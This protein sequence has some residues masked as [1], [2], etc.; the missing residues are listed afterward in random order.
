MTRI[1]VGVVDQGKEEKLKPFLDILAATGADVTVLAWGATA[2]AVVD[3]AAYDALVLC[4]GD[5]VDARRWGERNHPTVHLVPAR[6][7]EYE[8]AFARA[9]VE[10]GVPLL[11]VCRGSQIMNVALG[12]TLEQ[13]VPDVPGR[14]AHGDGAR[15]EIDVEP[16]TLLARLAPPRRRV[17]NSFHHQAV[18]RLAPSLRVAARCVDG[19]VEAV[20]GPGAFCLGVQ[21]HPEREG[22][23]EPLGSALFAELVKAAELR[24]ASDPA[25][26]S[27]LEVGP[28][29][30]QGR[31][32]G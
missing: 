28:S 5:D 3:A 18:G 2:D 12:G 6:R 22:C 7:D 23:D 29:G 11:G 8:L 27:K 30:R 1:R 13:H 26:S 20:E 21:W 9:A 17:V 14:V 16:G 15:H 24:R 19:V 4:G 25:R 32:V 31:S 10:R